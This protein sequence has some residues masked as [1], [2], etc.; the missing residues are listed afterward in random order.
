MRAVHSLIH[1]FIKWED[2]KDFPKNQVSIGVE[3]ILNRMTNLNEPI[4][5]IVFLHNITTSQTIININQINIKRKINQEKDIEAVRNVFVD[6]LDKDERRHHV[7]DLMVY[8]DFSNNNIKIV[9]RDPIVARFDH[10]LKYWENE[11]KEIDK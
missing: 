4:E 11:I 9:G 10:F 1:T 2:N 6:F 5:L 3:S 7:L 8:Y